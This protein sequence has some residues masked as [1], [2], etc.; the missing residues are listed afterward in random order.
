MVHQHVIGFLDFFLLYLFCRQIL[1]QC[2]FLLITTFGATWE[3]WKK[4]TKSQPS[5]LLHYSTL[6]DISTN[7]QQSTSFFY[8]ICAIW[9]QHFKVITTYGSTY[10]SI[11]NA[12]TCMAHVMCVIDYSWYVDHIKGVGYTQVLR[13]DQ[14]EKPCYI[15]KLRTWRKWRSRNCVVTSKLIGS[16]FLQIAYKKHFILSNMRVCPT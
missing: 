7:K 2:F 15:V 9:K 12:L 5:I 3:N 13:D 4:N 16:T 11:Q 8:N 6:T 14:I 1:A 10:D